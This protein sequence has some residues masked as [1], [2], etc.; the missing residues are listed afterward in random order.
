MNKEQASKLLSENL[1]AIY[2]YAFGKLYDKNQA[3]DL[4]SEIVCEVLR[5]IERLEKEEAFWGFVWS[6]AENTFRKFIRK[7]KYLKI[8]EWN[9][10]TF[11]GRYRHGFPQK[12]TAF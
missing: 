10:K 8:C 2:G 6:V 7:D 11:K 5:S 3:E 12:T 9:E 4:A 1:T